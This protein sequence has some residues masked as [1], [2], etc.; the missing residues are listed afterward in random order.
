[1]TYLTEIFRMGFQV[2]QRAFPRLAIPLYAWGGGLAV[3]TSVEQAVTWDRPS[4]VEDSLF[5]WRAMRDGDREFAFVDA[6]FENQA[7]PTLRSMLT[8]RRRWM[9]GTLQDD[10]QLPLRYYVLYAVRNLAWATTAVAPFLALATVALKVTVPLA[11]TLRSLGLLSLLALYV[12]SLL[13]WRYYRGSLPV[14]VALLV[15]TPLLAVLHAAG[16]LY[17]LVDRP[18][19]FTVT[20]KTVPESSAE[21]DTSKVTE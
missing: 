12:W 10:E 9:A 3:R 15:L 16:A 21:R 8:Q 1:V 19:D 11:G 18:S 5:V 17:G 20:E 6:R 2:E 13:G 14:G 7:P 4:L